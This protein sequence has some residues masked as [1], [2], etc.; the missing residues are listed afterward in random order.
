MVPTYYASRMHG[1]VFIFPRICK[2]A[3]VCTFVSL[4]GVAA[5]EESE[6]TFKFYLLSSTAAPSRSHDAY[7]GTMHI[8]CD[9]MH[10][11]MLLSVQLPSTE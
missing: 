8:I 7:F 4:A 5:L 10:T 3:Q 2:F 11:N 9:I 1:R 6:E